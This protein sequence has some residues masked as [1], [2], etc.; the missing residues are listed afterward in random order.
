M[1]GGSLLGFVCVSRS[2]VSD[3][4]T[5]RQGTVIVLYRYA[6]AIAHA[7]GFTNSDSSLSW[8]RR[9]FCWGNRASSLCFT[10]MH[11]SSVLTFTYMISSSILPLPARCLQKN[12]MTISHSC[13]RSIPLCRSFINTPHSHCFISQHPVHDFGIDGGYSPLRQ[14][15]LAGST[16]E[17]HIQ[18]CAGPYR[19]FLFTYSGSW[20]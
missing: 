19:Q 15:L 8:Q 11:E 18:T 10:C 12:I 9:S 2:G 3:D 13:P 1:R 14:I 16:P 4:R 7:T 20:R 5:S 6:M 17:P